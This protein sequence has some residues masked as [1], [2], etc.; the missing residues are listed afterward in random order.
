MKVKINTARTLGSANGKVTLRKTCQA[1]LPAVVAASSRDGSME[2]N[3]V[4]I[5][6]KTMGIQKT[7]HQNHPLHGKDIEQRCAGERHDRCIEN[8]CFGA[9]QHNPAD[10][11]DDPRNGE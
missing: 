7:L 5:N 3:G 10:D 9:E 11:L 8:P 6:R 4:D 1:V 2:R